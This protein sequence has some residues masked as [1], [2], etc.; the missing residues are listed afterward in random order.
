MKYALITGCSNGSIG[1]ALARAFA[2]HPPIYIFATS[3][4]ST[5]MT[6]LSS[7][8]NITLLEL[9]VTSRTSISTGLTAIQRTTSTTHFLVN[10][11]G[12]G[13]IMPFLDCPIEDCQTAFDVYVCGVMRVVQAFA[14]LVIAG[15]GT[16][17]LAGTTVE[18][19]G[20]PFQ[21]AYRNSKAA[22]FA[23]GDA[24]RRET[25]PLRVRVLVRQVL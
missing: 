3:R 2:K 18:V 13:Y 6:E 23:V 8:P 21:S 24:L 17:V 5:N 15:K 22:L 9:D 25:K 7:Y 16:I 4:T 12:L 10:H 14:P 20:V 1:S 11:A 19:L